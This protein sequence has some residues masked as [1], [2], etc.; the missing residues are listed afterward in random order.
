MSRGETAV[1]WPEPPRWTRDALIAQ[2]REALR[3]RVREAYLIG[4][5]AAGTADRD[6][7][8]DLILVCDT[9]RP[10]PERAQEFDDLF[11]RHRLENLDLVIYT[12]AEWEKLRAAPS[13]FLWQASQN[14]ER[15]F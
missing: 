8:V 13:S 1:I 4:S 14:W 7:D 3:G 12:A 15:L 11:H 9:H 6:S 10:W 2:L 5:H